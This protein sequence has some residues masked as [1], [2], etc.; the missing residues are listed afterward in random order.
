MLASASVFVCVNVRSLAYG[1]FSDICPKPNNISIASALAISF[2]CE[3][4][5]E[6]NFSNFAVRFY[7]FILEFIYCLTLCR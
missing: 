5:L 7:V 2:A 3:Q 4:F 6:S 1:R